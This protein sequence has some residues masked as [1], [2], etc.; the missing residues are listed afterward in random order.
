MTFCL[1]MKVED[2]LV[3]LADTR[4]TTGNEYLSARKVTVH[5]T[6]SGHSMFLMTSGLRSVRDKTLTYF[7]EMLESQ[8]GGF[9]HLYKLVNAFADQLRRVADEDREALLQG[10]LN[11]NLF[12][13]VAGRLSDDK[14]HKLYLLYP[15]ANWVEAGRSSPYFIIGNTNYGKPILNRILTYESSMAF[16]LKAGYLAFDATR[17]SATDVGF[18]VD[19]AIMQRDAKEVRVT[20]YEEDAL[21]DCSQYWQNHIARGLEDMRAPWVEQ[22]FRA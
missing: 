7:E 9:N 19:V 17:I 21:R 13:L 4:I 1:I 16:A 18:P 14:E 22:A 5:S 8:V 15:Q 6:D 12:A 3:G 20:R 11:F 2:G 10:G